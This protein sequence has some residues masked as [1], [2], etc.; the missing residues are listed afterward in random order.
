MWELARRTVDT[1]VK[2]RVMYKLFIKAEDATQDYDAMAN[3]IKDTVDDFV[4]RG[5]LERRL[6]DRLLTGTSDRFAHLVT[7][8][9]LP[10]P[11]K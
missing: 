7:L 6:G 1:E 11:A 8:P 5:L 10:P 2:R 4:R 3:A 9:G